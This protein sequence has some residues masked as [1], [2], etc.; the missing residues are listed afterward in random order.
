MHRTHT[1]LPSGGARQDE[2]GVRSHQHDERTGGD[3]AGLT[4]NI[5]LPEG[6]SIAVREHVLHGGR[7]GEPT[8][9][10]AGELLK[11]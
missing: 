7:S 1:I 4:D 10:Q 11:P 3:T 8:R 2:F 9:H 6:A 5:P